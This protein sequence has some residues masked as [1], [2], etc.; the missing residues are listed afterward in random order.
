MKVIRDSGSASSLIQ[1]PSAITIG[2]FDGV[3]A[4][5]QKVLA[6]LLRVKEENGLA[7]SVLITFDKH[8]LSV[9]HPEM[10][11]PLLTTLDEKLSL[12]GKMGVDN[13]LVENFS[14]EYSETDYR[15]F[16]RRGL[17]ERLSMAHLVI[18]YD[19]R[20][21]KGRRGSPEMIKRESRLGPFG[22]TV[23]P[24]RKIGEDIVSSSRIRSYILEREMEKASRS[25][26]R[27]YFFDARVVRGNRIGKEIDFPTANLEVDSKDKLV[28]PRGVYAVIAEIGEKSYL[29]MMNVG[30][31]PTVLG[32]GK[33]ERIEVHLLD[34]SRNI[35]GEK[36]RVRCRSFIREERPFRGIEELKGQLKRDREKVRNILSV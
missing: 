18:G 11:P 7:G 20:L 31:S 35:Y 8:P 9:T 25:L 13:V 19:L 32:T 12:I 5:H 2:V 26:T 1:G 22:L 10:A 21:G 16:I 4:G 17:V 24:P 27:D 28:P 30:S 3:H 23:V 34:F 36:I 14:R 15:R 6:S 29:G 33:R